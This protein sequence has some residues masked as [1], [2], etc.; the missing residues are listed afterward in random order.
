M[1]VDRGGGVRG[2]HHSGGLQRRS[3]VTFR[4]K[5]SKSFRSTKNVEK[6]KDRRRAGT[7]QLS[8]GI[9][10]STPPA[11]VLIQTIFGTPRKWSAQSNRAPA[12]QAEGL[13]ATR[14]VM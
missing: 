9:V 4:Q 7:H 5:S 2:D 3:Q 1:G 14:T 10:F 13:R 11:G 12:R 8:T 6:R